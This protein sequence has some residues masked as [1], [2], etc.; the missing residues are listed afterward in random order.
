MELLSKP[1]IR[2]NTTRK[3]K[4]KKYDYFNHQK[5]GLVDKA[6]GLKEFRFTGCTVTDLS[7][8][9]WQVVK[10]PCPQFPPL[11]HGQMQLHLY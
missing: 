1:K 4:K 2:L 3:E 10:L 9:L 5:H 11:K 8:D 6:L 7:C